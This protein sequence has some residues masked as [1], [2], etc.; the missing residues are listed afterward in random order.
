MIL[1]TRWQEPIKHLCSGVCN[2]VLRH[3]Y[4]QTKNKNRKADDFRFCIFIWERRYAE[5]PTCHQ[6]CS[7][8]I[9]SSVLLSLEMLAL[10]IDIGLG[11]RVTESRQLK[12]ICNRRGRHKRVPDKEERFSPP[13]PSLWTLLFESQ[14]SILIASQPEYLTV[15]SRGSDVRVRV[16]RR[17]WSQKRNSQEGAPLLETDTGGNTYFSISQTKSLDIITDAYSFFFFKN[18]Q[19]VTSNYMTMSNHTGHLLHFEMFLA[20]PLVTCS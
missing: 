5:I 19:P 10:W 4:K 18:L 6:L 15:P 8:F 13:P 17:Q 12:Q 14:F 7:G 16:T 11:A 2:S 20:F 9:H 3:D 1:K